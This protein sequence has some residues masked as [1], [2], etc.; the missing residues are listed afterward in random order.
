MYQIFMIL[1]R[2]L[3]EICYAVI[4]SL[5]VLGINRYLFHL[6]LSWNWLQLF[7]YTVMYCIDTCTLPVWY[8]NQPNLYYFVEICSWNVCATIGKS[9]LH[10]W[11]LSPF[12][13]LLGKLSSLSLLFLLSRL[14]YNNY[15]KYNYIY[16]MN[17][18]LLPL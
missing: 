5:N 18:K 9:I 1:I 7:R 16:P 2:L 11:L 6:R 8:Q 15:S 12:V 17:A 13:C 14:W 4:A 10:S 3:V